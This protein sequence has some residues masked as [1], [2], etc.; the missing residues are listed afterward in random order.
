MSK[1]GSTQFKLKKDMKGS[2]YSDDPFK[3]KI[4]LKN[5]EGLNRSAIED[6]KFEL[7][8]DTFALR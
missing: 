2:N 1:Q 6:I 4:N 5:Y 8:N 3:K 7:L